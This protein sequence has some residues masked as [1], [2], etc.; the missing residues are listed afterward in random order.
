MPVPML[1]RLIDESARL[2]DRDGYNHVSME[3]IA[4]AVGLAKPSLYHYVR[5]KDQILVLIH[6]EFMALTLTRAE[7]LDRSR[8]APRDQL[9]EIMGDILELMH[10]HRGH[11][12]VFWEHHRELPRQVQKKIAQ[13]RRRYLEI[14][15]KILSRGVASGDFRPLNVSLAALAVF[16][17]CNWAYQWYDV[18]GKLSSRDI[19]L[20]FADFL[21]RGIS[22]TSR[23]RSRQHGRK[24]SRQHLAS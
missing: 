22:G 1:R 9:L 8:L 19:A 16:G 21:L 10:S 11:V 7:S 13:D 15:R 23:T 6:Q 4:A 24:S 14:V 17:M 18:R 20:M 2:F 12:R 5:S 3:A